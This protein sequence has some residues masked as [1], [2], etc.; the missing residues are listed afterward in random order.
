MVE[1]LGAP[2]VPVTRPI[3][4]DANPPSLVVAFVIEVARAESV[5]IIPGTAGAELQLSFPSMLNEVPEKFVRVLGGVGPAL[6][7]DPSPKL[8]RP[9]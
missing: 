6:L 8:P 7:I 9:I 1:T 2:P 4:F 5:T 3:W